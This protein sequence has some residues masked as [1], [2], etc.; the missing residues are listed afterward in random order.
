[1]SVCVFAMYVVI[2]GVDF[3]CVGEWCV[4]ERKGMKSTKS[5]RL[6]RLGRV[7]RVGEM[8]KSGYSGEIVVELG[9]SGMWRGMVVK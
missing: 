8:G 7:E 2:N 6:A 1:V 4:C 9:V 5:T 3:A